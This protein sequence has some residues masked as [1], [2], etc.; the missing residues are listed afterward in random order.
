M[1]ALRKA[2]ETNATRAWV[3]LPPGAGKTLVG[4]EMARE[5][6]RPTLILSPNT[7]IQGQWVAAADQFAP[8]LPV[9]TSRTLS[10][11]ITSLTY[12]SIA[13][14][15]EVDG[16]E[17]HID[18][19]RDSGREIVN[20]L[21]AHGDVLLILDE[22]HHLLAT[23]GELLSEVLALLPGAFV[24]GLTGTPPQA[25]STRETELMNEVLGSCAYAASPNALVRDGAIAPYQDLN[26][27]VTPTNDESVYLADTSRK[28]DADR[29]LTNSS[30]KGD[31][32][33]RI[34]KAEHG[35]RGT[36]LRAL[37]LCDYETMTAKTDDS[38]PGSAENV[39]RRMTADPHT[40]ALNPVMVTGSRVLAPAS[41]ARTLAAWIHENYPHL[42]LDE[43]ATGSDT[44]LVP[45]TGAWTSSEW[46]KAITQWFQTESGHVLV[47]TRALLG[48]GWDAPATNVVIDLTSAATSMAVAQGRGRALRI[49]KNDPSKVASLWSVTCIDPY[50]P[51][52]NPDYD[53]LVRK[54]Q[55]YFTMD[56]NRTIVTGNTVLPT[57]DDA[58]AST[59]A[60]NAV[61]LARAANTAH[62]AALWGVGTA[63]RNRKFPWVE[64]DIQ[65][66]DA[67]A[68][69]YLG[70]NG[71]KQEP[72]G[73]YAPAYKG[74]K[75]GL[76]GGVKVDLLDSPENRYSVAS[77]IAAAVAST[78]NE[79]GLIRAD[80][81]DMRIK[82]TADGKA[83]FW[84]ETESTDDAELFA[85]TFS[86]CFDLTVDADS[87]HFPAHG[88][89]R[90][91]FDRV[92]TATVKTPFQAVTSF[93]PV[94]KAIRRDANLLAIYNK[95]W[96]RW[97]STTWTEL[98][99]W[100]Y[101][102]WTGGA[103]AGETWH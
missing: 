10:T 55:A 19:L 63:Y 60:V 6:H 89:T 86:Q 52:Y 14:F 54:A 69:R 30:S 75:K 74:K 46:V 98:H 44:A 7:A 25:M 32:A 56:E 92:N 93:H 72:A 100:T 67:I 41:T 43:I 68:L 83:R 20:A 8:A 59:D 95:A 76:F 57:L 64:I 66:T 5:F 23:W 39:I 81:N 40:R 99:G 82:V 102:E 29:L 15:T 24:L 37:V 65:A 1:K 50:D 3:S 91:D 31:G 4:L 85:S 87:L 96:T 73:L 78:L 45:V 36:A 53:R 80:W 16:A 48:E 21:A 47:G 94:P 62:V 103:T 17:N 79:A 101:A 11:P 35:A 42:F 70:V 77:S 90:A 49:D 84:L 9:G 51:S 28:R 27:F 13:Q 58:L 61:M 88:V 18:R 26:L 38:A 12:Q 2:Y 71:Y 22:A 97:V 34:I 33:V